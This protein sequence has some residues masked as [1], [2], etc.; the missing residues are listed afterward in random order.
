MDIPSNGN[1]ERGDSAQQMIPPVHA[2][3]SEYV[4]VRYRNRMS[5]FPGI[6]PSLVPEETP[7][8]RMV[9]VVDGRK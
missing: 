2:L 1:T 9:G 3:G 4:A 7:P 6:D 8:W 5:D